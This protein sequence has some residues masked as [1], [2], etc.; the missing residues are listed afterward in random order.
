MKRLFIFLMTGLLIV[1]C[2]EEKS[3][4][5]MQIDSLGTTKVD[6]LN[7]TDTS[8]TLVQDSLSLF[9]NKK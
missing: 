2:S 1:A 9:K 4:T 6:L 5:D 8:K 7:Q 3:K